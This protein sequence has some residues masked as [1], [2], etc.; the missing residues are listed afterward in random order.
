MSRRIPAAT[1]PWAVTTA[2]TPRPGRGRTSRTGS[3]RTGTLGPGGEL[4]EAQR[5]GG[6][7]QLALHRPQTVLVGRPAASAPGPS[8]RPWSPCAAARAPRRPPSARRS[9]RGR[10]PRRGRPRAGRARAG[11]SPRSCRGW[12]LPGLQVD[13]DDPP[14]VVDLEPVGVPRAGRPLAVGQRHLGAHVLLGGQHRA[15]VRAGCARSTNRVSALRTS[16]CSR[17][18]D[19]GVRKPS[20]SHTSS[21][22]TISSSTVPGVG[23]QA[24]PWRPGRRSRAPG[25]RSP[26]PGWTCARHRPRARGTTSPGT[27][28]ARPGHWPRARRVRR[29]AA[30]VAAAWL[31]SRVPHHVAGSAAGTSGRPS[32]RR[33]AASRA[34]RARR[35]RGSIGWTAGPTPCGAAR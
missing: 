19:H 7:H 31:R 17:P 21:T 24:R 10:R 30:P 28:P 29:P 18:R 15:G 11:G 4:L 5:G 14:G 3:A 9:R 26:G 23:L 2:P 32:G 27:R 12:V 6:L 22:S 35:P 8:A 13:H 20:W 33:S 25:C 1:R 16:S 34:S